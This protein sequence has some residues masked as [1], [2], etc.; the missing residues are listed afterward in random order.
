MNYQL[1]CQNKVYKILVVFRKFNRPTQPNYKF[2]NLLNMYRKRKPA[3][4]FK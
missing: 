4:F 3:D 1:L 2:I